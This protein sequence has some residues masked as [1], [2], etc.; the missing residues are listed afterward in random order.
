MALAIL[1]SVFEHNHPIP[2]KYTCDGLNLSPPLLISDSPEGVQ[3][4]ALIVD[5]PDAPGGAF[6]HWLVWNI[7]P[8]VRALEEGKAPDGALQGK[9]DFG[10]T[11]WGGPCPP[12]GHGPHHYHF[13]LYALNQTLDLAPGAGKREVEQAMEGHILASAVL[14]GIYERS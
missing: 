1:S 10:E 7:P 14:V 9:N 5:D 12:K 2:Q 8:L 4:F 13:K 6:V 3:S 11:K